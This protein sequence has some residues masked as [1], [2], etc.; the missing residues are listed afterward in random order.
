MA[1]SKTVERM[2]NRL[3]YG[4]LTLVY[5]GM[6]LMVAGI[7]YFSFQLEKNSQ[8]VIAKAH[9]VSTLEKSIT[10]RWQSSSSLDEELSS[11]I[12]EYLAEKSNLKNLESEI[13]AANKSV[14]DYG[15][16]LAL[17][18]IGLACAGFYPFYLGI[19]RRQEK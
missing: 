6:A 11:M 13:D 4:G 18:G 17:A 14:S 2:T 16:I 1:E 9:Q 10:D 19:R 7:G 5:T 8:P 15:M 12:K 3:L